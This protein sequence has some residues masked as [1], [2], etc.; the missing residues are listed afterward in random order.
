ML[1]TIESTLDFEIEEQPSY[2]YKV[3]FKKERARGNTDDVA[4]LRQAITK[5]LATERYNYIIYS[6][7]YGIEL[8]D[9]YGQ[10]IPTVIPQLPARITA[11]LMQDDRITGCSDFDISY[12]GRKITCKFS[13]QNTLSDEALTEETVIQV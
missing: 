13:V 9:L 11:A 2:T 3:D 8:V 6:W 1:P 10:P 5:I 4:A 12:E 7:N